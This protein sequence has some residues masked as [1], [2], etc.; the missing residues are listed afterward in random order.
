MIQA[1]FLLSVVAGALTLGAAI[2]IARTHWRL[3]IEPYRER[4]SFSVLRRPSSY[5]Q[6]DWVG[7]VR[8]L[9]L[10]GCCLIAVA[11]GCLTYQLAVD[12]AR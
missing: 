4:Y 2:G 7:S 6:P 12:L 1:L 9:A 11:V 5:V 8:V 3:D 10:V